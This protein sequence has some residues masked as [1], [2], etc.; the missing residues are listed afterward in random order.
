LFVSG[1][2]GSFLER[3]KARGKGVRSGHLQRWRSDRAGR[4]QSSAE[5]DVCGRGGG[6]FAAKPADARGWL[7]DL[8][9]VFPA[10]YVD[11]PVCRFVGAPG[12]QCTSAPIHQRT[13]TPMRRYTNAPAR[14]CTDTPA[15]QCTGPP[16]HQFSSLTEISVRCWK[17]TI[18]FTARA[19]R[20]CE[21]KQIG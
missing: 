11:T 21:C 17:N 5:V 19:C 8:C 10:G 16:M 1:T 20:L 4:P 7:A 14:Q 15:R 6:G 12:H 18:I 2:C 9:A 3:H 13:D